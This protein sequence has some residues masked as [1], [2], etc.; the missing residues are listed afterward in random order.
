M[1]NS[2]GL[3]EPLNSFNV[4]VELL[5]LASGK[6]VYR[7]INRTIF[8]LNEITVTNAM[9]TT[10]RNSSN[11]SSGSSSS[12]SDED[13]SSEPKVM[14][15]SQM[16]QQKVGKRK[17]ETVE[18]KKEK[19]SEDIDD[20]I[21][22]LEAELAQDSDSSDSDSES[23]SESDSDASDENERRK[24]RIRF[25]E[26][27]IMNPEN[28]VEKG[29]SNDDVICMSKCASDSIKPLPKEV[30]PTSKTRKLKVDREDTKSRLPDERSR[31][32]KSGCTIS[33]GLK[34]AVNEVLSNYVAR[35][36]EKIPFYCRVCLHQSESH[37]EFIA[38]K[39]TEF[40]EAAVQVEKKAT[41]CNLCR[42]QL[43]SLV[44]MQEHLESRPHRER[45]DDVKARQRG[46]TN[47]RY[48]DRGRGGRGRFSG[49]GRGERDA[50]GRFGDRGRGGRW[51]S[52]GR[53]R[54]GGRYSHTD[55]GGRNG[56]KGDWR[57]QQSRDTRQWG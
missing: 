35:S 9:V 36:C 17:R 13:E 43:T 53:G 32:K 40:H 54:G 26:S 14:T 20:E 37:E 49:R 52:N 45:M 25:G 18:V 56:F 46:F 1:Y 15:A 38:H 34:D 57:T 39:R 27:T 11:C 10:N 5:L 8:G 44:Q 16:M 28:Y 23:D 12:S 3:G 31:S 4:F 7:R 2:C 41:Y 47:I 6:K 29:L 19:A 48:S 55:R 42:K 21:K 22:R 51:N 24:K 50:G 33:N 30:L